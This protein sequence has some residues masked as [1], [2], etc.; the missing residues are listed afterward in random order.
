MYAIR[1]FTAP[2]LAVLA[3][4]G[5]VVAAVVTGSRPIADDL[6]IGVV[7]TTYA[8]VALVIELAR[9]GHPVGR[10]MLAGATAWG[11]GEALLAL[12]LAGFADASAPAA[13]VVLGVV[14]SATRGFGWLL[15]ILALPLVFP[16]GRAP[17]RG[18]VALVASCISAF[19]IATLVAP[20]PLE[21]RLETAVNPLGV[22]QSWKPFADLLALG[23]IA[24]AF[25]GLLVAVATLVRRWHAGGELVRQQILVFGAA[26]A[27]PL[28][29][30]PLVATPWAQ[31][32]MFALVTLPVPA[33]VAVAMFQRRLYDLQFAAN[34]TLTY[35]ALS[36]MLA[37]VYA[38]VVVGVGVVLHDSGAAWLQWAA[39]GVVAMAFAPLRD[40]L[41]RAAN[42]VTHGRWS[43]PAA[44]LADTG[45]RLADAADGPAL[46]ESLTHELVHGLGLAHAEIRDTTGRR[47][48][49]TGPVPDEVE[50]LPLTAYGGRVGELRW[51][52]GPLRPSER[53][54]LLDLAHQVGG[55]VHTT[56]LVES[57]REAREQ[58]VLGREQERR[59]L[60]R[61]LH[62]GLGPQLA[63]LGLQLDTVH[64]LLAAGRPVDDRLAQLRAGLQGTVAEVRRIVEGLRPPAIDELGLFAAVAELGRQLTDD[65][66]VVL[67]MDLSEER[68]VLPAAVEVA[69]YRVAQEALTNVVR[70]AGATCCRVRGAVADGDLV[71]EVVD[72]GHG[73]ARPGRGVGLSSMR[74]R[75]REIGGWIE[76]DSPPGGT[77][78]T[79]RLPL[80][81]E[82]A[83]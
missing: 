4:A 43:T 40:W 25:V 77:T 81:A 53:G 48:A 73:G 57:L 64:N 2:L 68:P 26:F 71:L 41:Q 19:T 45:R 80:T 59:R 74:E 16:D 54:L 14:G 23:A 42:R 66:G 29:L 78:V 33:A 9:P 63:A 7:V 36:V 11:I 10:L 22:P 69:A 21:T 6:A 8:L 83:T 72:D 62:D 65:S 79:I 61:D 35:L 17:G 47:L 30:L 44:V 76:V 13:Y 75:V 27:A 37:A 39:A 32:W 56:A 52:A 12:G 70:H 15:L 34:R 5:A 18:P 1:L 31:P 50:T 46:L 67:T 24:A 20:I 28:L 3:I 60:R 82:P 49:A 55:V 38:I 58:L 51:A